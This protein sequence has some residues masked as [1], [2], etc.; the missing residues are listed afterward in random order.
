MESLDSDNRVK[1][2]VVTGEGRQFSVGADSRALSHYTEVDENYAE[3]VNMPGMSTPGYGVRPEFDHDMVWHWGL[4]KPVI[5]AINGACAGIATVLASFCDFRYAAEGIKFTPAASRLGLPAEYGLSWVLPRIVGLTHTL[6]ILMTNRILRSEELMQMGY[7]NG[8][9]PLD[10]FLE[11]VYEVAAA[12]A[13]ETSAESLHAIKRQVY[14]DLLRHDVGASVEES[15]ELIGELMKRP[16]YKEGVRALRDG[17]TP[18]FNL[19]TVGE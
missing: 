19:A 5:A 10:G 13:V 7:L 6:D 4:R 17:R 15:K 14:E 16:D 3:S 1:I 12:L 18:D 8:L 11:R 9:Y 2:I